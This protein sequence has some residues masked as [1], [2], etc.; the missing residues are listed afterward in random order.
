MSA[1]FDFLEVVTLPGGTTGGDCGTGD[2]RA[3]RIAGLGEVI[4]VLVDV[5]TNICGL[6]SEA[7]SPSGR[8][9]GLI[10]LN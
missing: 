10:C 4:S 7:I 8:G 6:E 5:A 1:S 9:I 3:T 2:G